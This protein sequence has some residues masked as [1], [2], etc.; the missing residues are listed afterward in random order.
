MKQLFGRSK[1]VKEHLPPQPPPYGNGSA[2]GTVYSALHSS[3][4]LPSSTGARTES[5]SPMAPRSPNNFQQPHTHYAS[6]PNFRHAL[7][8]D[9]DPN[10]RTQDGNT[11]LHRVVKN[12]QPREAE[13]LIARG[14]DVNAQNNEGSTPLHEAALLGKAEMVKVLIQHGAKPSAS[15]R[16]GTTPLHNAAL[17]GSCST[18]RALCDGGADVNAV[19]KQ[20]STP[21]HWAAGHEE[22]SAVLELLNHRANPNACNARGDTPLHEAAVLSKGEIAKV[23]LEGGGDP[24]LRNIDGKTASE[25]A[26]NESM[27]NVLNPASHRHAVARAVA[28]A[29]GAAVVGGGILAAGVVAA[30]LLEAGVQVATAVMPFA[31][32]IRGIVFLAAELD[33]LNDIC[34]ANKAR[35]A[36]LARQARE[37]RSLVEPLLTDQSSARHI[38]LGNEADVHTTVSR[39]QYVQDTLATAK[40]M[41]EKW[42]RKEGEL[43]FELKRFLRGDVYER[44]FIL[45]AENMRDALTALRTDIL[46]RVYVKMQKPDNAEKYWV[47]ELQQGA[48]KDHE[49]L[50]MIVAKN[51]GER[52]S[53]LMQ[54]LGDIRKMAPKVDA[55][56]RKV[57]D[58]QAQLNDF[59]KNLQMSQAKLRQFEWEELKIATGNFNA[60][61]KIG[62]GAFGPVYFGTV[63]GTPVAIKR[64]NQHGQQGTTE[65]DK[66]LQVLGYVRHPHIVALMG[67]HSVPG[68]QSL[69]YEFCEQGSLE[70]RLLCRGNTPPL[71]WD[72]RLAIAVQAARGLL[73]LHS[74]PT[75]IIH[76]DFKT[77]NVLLDTNFNAKVGD[78][79]LARLAPE[80]AFGART[81]KMSVLMDSS[82][83]GTLL[84]VDPEYY[85]SGQLGPK[86]DVYSFGIVLL[87]MLTG[88]P[89]LNLYG[90]VSDAL[91]EG[92]L[93]KI[94]D[95]K[96]EPWPERIAE[97][98]ADLA[99]KCASLDRH[100]RP[101]LAQEVLPTLERLNREGVA[102]RSRAR[103]DVDQSPDI[104]CFFC[105][106][107][108]QI[109]TDPVVAADGYSYEKVAIEQW[110]VQNEVSPMTG[111]RMPHKQL[112]INTNLQRAISQLSLR[113]VS[114][115]P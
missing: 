59:L 8:A 23:L 105:P 73:F 93:Y 40:E 45:V 84:Y 110:F 107:T 87:E 53:E 24:T 30:G 5:F 109:M 7:P 48:V 12:G 64:L 10:A 31:G 82:P 102:C 108:S 57:T 97:E 15:N 43:L 9:A 51:G 16:D 65:F 99:I 39:L 21:L 56:D 19:N 89:P 18:I 26:E 76:R 11:L 28:A 22:T 17:S 91:R 36:S 85:R 25:K 60:K 103:P 112:T 49:E 86:S 54:L 33:R 92:Q 68:Q 90:L 98:L 113:S 35:C 38:Q 80:L 50:P 75:P 67:H 106:I 44:K 71:P 78:F 46:L 94:A 34:N 4:S 32:C 81:M 2:S 69:V 3:P 14:A 114:S 100:C 88:K 77:A 79:G 104:D 58:M 1:K 42:T 72:K 115:S 55:I 62:E 47:R 41:V 20:N 63:A 101:D 52:D 111:E 27:R 61:N 96:P 95:S 70:D 13:V 37:I 74:L 6:A 66:E 83:G 29:G